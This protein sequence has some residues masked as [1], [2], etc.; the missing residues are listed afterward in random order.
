MESG[1][2]DIYLGY[3]IYEV[4]DLQNGQC[5]E[6]TAADLSI[7]AGVKK[8]MINNLARKN[9][10][11]KKRYQFWM[12]SEEVKQKSKDIEQQWGEVCQIYYEVKV[13]KRDIRR[14]VDGKLYAVRVL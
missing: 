13:G 7:L 5:A 1:K 2:E 12:L 4:K 6:G 14:A 11:Y 9:V 10:V 3:M 8:S